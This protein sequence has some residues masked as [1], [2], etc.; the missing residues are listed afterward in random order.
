EQLGPWAILVN[1]YDIEA[2]ASAIQRAVS[3]TAE[4]RRPA[5]ERLR[6]TTQ[7]ENVYWWLS[8]F[9]A[10]CGVTLKKQ[11]EPLVDVEA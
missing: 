5:M 7:A 3:M 2:V 9:M 10:R 8:R 11:E 6:A 1:P 4:Q